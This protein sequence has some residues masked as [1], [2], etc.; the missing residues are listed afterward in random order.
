MSFVCYEFKCM[1]SLR[2][3]QYYARVIWKVNNW[4]SSS[5][6]VVPSI[7]FSTNFITW[8]KGR[9]GKKNSGTRLKR[10]MESSR[11]SKIQKKVVKKCLGVHRTESKLCK[12]KERDT[13]KHIVI[14]NNMKLMSKD[15]ANI[16]NSMFVS[17]SLSSQHCT[18]KF[19]PMLL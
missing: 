11:M 1:R 3:T 13:R 6:R 12:K 16:V 18:Y 7:F 4:N 10:T 15:Y 9:N 17:K 8:I 14:T 19:D 2:Q 5:V